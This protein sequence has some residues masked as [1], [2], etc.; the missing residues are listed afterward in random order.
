MIRTACAWVLVLLAISPVTAPFSTCDLTSLCTRASYTLSASTLQP[1]SAI[2]LAGASGADAYC[3]SPLVARTASPDDAVARV[4]PPF[5]PPLAA[6]TLRRAV[7]STNSPH[8][9]S[10]GALAL[11][12]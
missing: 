11:R 4:L 5:T 12:V 6:R 2:T 3:V 7:R 8:C 1:Q 10:G 9:E